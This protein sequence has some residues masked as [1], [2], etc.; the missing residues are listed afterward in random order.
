[1]GRHSQIVL[2]AGALLSLLAGCGPSFGPKAVHGIVFY[3]PGAGNVDF[4]DQGI[5][6]GLEQAGYPGQVASVM[7]TVSFVAPI[8]QR[9]GN[10]RL[11]G[12]RLARH[13]EQYI[14]EYPDGEV[15]LIGLSAGTGVVIWALEN[16][17]PGYY[18]NNV[19]LLS[20][21]LYYQYDITKALPRVRGRIYNYYSSEDA[22]LT[23]LMKP[24]GTI[25]GVPFADGAG[26]VGLQPP[27]GADRVTNIA[28]RPEFRQYGYYGGHTD[29]TSPDFVRVSIA[30]HVMADQPAVP[31]HA[32]LATDPAR[33]SPAGR[34]D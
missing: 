10:A 24:I 13:I 7:W 9:L 15:N 22:V 27:K 14:D 6:R 8:D 16:L 17:K 28:W 1:M 23:V 34:P 12:L 19:V 25:D 5:R 21:S 20:S 4:G 26:A 31:Q 30:R 11:G 3:A 2:V 18:V 33:W 32:A 29:V